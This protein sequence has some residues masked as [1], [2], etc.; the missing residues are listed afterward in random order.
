MTE[1]NNIKILGKGYK[2]WVRMYNGPVYAPA[3]GL[4][5]LA[6]DAD[7]HVEY[8]LIFL[9]EGDDIWHKFCKLFPDEYKRD[10]YAFGGYHAPIA[11][12][13]IPLYEENSKF[14]KDGKEYLK[15]KKSNKDYRWF[16]V[17]VKVF[18]YNSK[19]YY[20]LNDCFYADIISPFSMEN[21]NYN[22]DDY[23]N[24][25]ELSVIDNNIIAVHEAFRY[26]HLDGV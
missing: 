20:C 14:W 7:M 13:H 17:F 1:A 2:K 22:D 23:C 6:I 5:I 18:S 8:D 24:F 21:K 15:N 19:F 10:S 3:K 25:E 12:H 4:Y 26:D 11:Y 9:E 16:N